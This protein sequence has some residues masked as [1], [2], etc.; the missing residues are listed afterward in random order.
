MQEA[1]QFLRQNPIQ[2][3]ATVAP[4]GKPKVRPFQFMLERGGKF[5]FCTSTE[6]EVYRQI[7]QAP[8]VEFCASSQSGEWMR[9]KGKVVFS[10][11]LEI[12]T[13]ILAQNPLVKSLYQSPDNP[14]FAIF[15]LDDCMATICD[16]SGNPPKQYAL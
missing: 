9:M 5:Y 7:R 4:D 16:F 6:K 10:G 12:K 15:Y 13:E 1:L 2:Y 3:L 14:V 8:D 11:D